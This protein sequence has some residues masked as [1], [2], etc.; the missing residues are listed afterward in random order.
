MRLAQGKCNHAKNVLSTFWNVNIPSLSYWV[1]LEVTVKFKLMPA[2][3]PGVPQ[4]VGGLL[5]DLERV[6]QG[7]RR[8]IRE[9]NHLC[10]ASTRVSSPTTVQQCAVTVLSI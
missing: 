8:H 7:W 5:M 9:L 2:Q 4:L 3:E 1:P 10:S 6:F